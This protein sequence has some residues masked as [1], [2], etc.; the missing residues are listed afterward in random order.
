LG[1]LFN[2]DYAFLIRKPL[3]TST[4][5]ELL[6]Y[7]KYWGALLLGGLMGLVHF[8][9]NAFS[10]GMRQRKFELL[11]A[12]WLLA[13]GLMLVMG[14]PRFSLH[15]ALPLLPPLIFYFSFW[16]EQVRFPRL[17]RVLVNLALLPAAITFSLYL[18][19]VWPSGRQILREIVKPDG[20]VAQQFGRLYVPDQAEAYADDLRARGLAGPIWVAEAQP[21]LYYWLGR[22]MATP[23]LSFPMVYHLMDFLSHNRRRVGLITPAESLVRVHAHFETQ[24]PVYVIDPNGIFGEIKQR[25]PLLLADYEADQVNGVTIYWRDTTRGVLRPVPP[26]PLVLRSVLPPAG[27]G[28]PDSLL[29]LSLR[30]IAPDTTPLSPADSLLDSILATQPLPGWPLWWASGLL[31]F[32]PPV[33]AATTPAAPASADSLAGDSLPRLPQPPPPNVPRTAQP[34][35][36]PNTQTPQPAPGMPPNAPT[37]QPPPPPD[38]AE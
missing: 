35:T 30:P 7:T 36:G 8:R 18:L 23:Y 22:P 29:P 38:D 21:E 26:P 2:L 27:A 28:L 1:I 4:G 3:E 12:F 9:R 16:V 34:P 6:E 20:W 11:M 24:K 14:R 5:W 32:G 31:G 37:P 33:A 19:L 13:A 25:L 10:F 15:E 17:G